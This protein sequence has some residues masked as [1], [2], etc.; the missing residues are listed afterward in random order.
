LL[1][2][3]SHLPFPKIGSPKILE[4]L[5]FGPVYLAMCIFLDFFVPATVHLKILKFELQQLFEK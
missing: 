4:I 5:V 1:F 2:F 3:V